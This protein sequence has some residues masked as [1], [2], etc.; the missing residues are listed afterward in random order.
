MNKNRKPTRRLNN[1]SGDANI[2][3]EFSSHFCKV[4]ECNT[5][6]ADVKYKTLVSEYLDSMVSRDES[7]DCSPITS[8]TVQE[9]IENL[10][11]RKSAGQDGITNEHCVWRASPGCTFV[12]AVYC[13]VKAFFCTKQFP[14]WYHST[15]SQR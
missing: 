12:S 5:K 8:N 3:D 10:R 14:I 1:Q 6:G 15:Y 7:V 13:H 4:S 2:L 9:I 11:P